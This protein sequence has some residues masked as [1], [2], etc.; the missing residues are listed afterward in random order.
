[1]PL[2]EGVRTG[3]GK[4]IMGWLFFELYYIRETVNIHVTMIQLGL[5]I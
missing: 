3:G 1:M 4:N 5:V 2:A